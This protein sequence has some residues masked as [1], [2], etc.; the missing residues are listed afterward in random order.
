M[1]TVAIKTG[2]KEENIAI[3][4]RRML[5]VED[6]PIQAISLERLLCKEGY[7]VDWAKNG[8]EALEKARANRPNL[9]LTDTIM[10]VM[11]G[12]QLSVKLKQDK[13]LRDIPLIIIGALEETGDI[14]K[15]LECG[16]EHYITKPFDEDFLTDKVDFVIR[17]PIP[18]KNLPEEKCIEIPYDRDCFK[19]HAGRGQSLCLLLSTYENI[20]VRNKKMKQLQEELISLNESRKSKEQERKKSLT[21]GIKEHRRVIDELEQICWMLSPR[22]LSSQIGRYADSD[23]AQGYGD[24]TLLNFDG[25]ISSHVD[26]P[27][28]LGI[29]SEYMDLLETSSAIHEKNGS[30]AFN[31]HSSRWCR[32]LNIASRKLCQTKDNATALASNKWLCHES[33]WTHCSKEAIATG[34]TLDI[35]CNGGIRIYSEPIFVN[36]EAIGAINF[37]YGD[38][39]KDPVTLQKIADTYGVEYEELSRVADAYE[40][41]PPF[42]I[43][44]AK[45]RLKVSASLIGLLVE[46]EIAEVEQK[47]LQAQLIQAQKMEAIGTLTGGIA[48]DFNN[49][50]TVILGYLDLAMIQL[51]PDLPVYANLQVAQNASQRAAGIVKQLLIF[52]R[53]QPMEESIINLNNNIENLLKMLNRFVGEDIHLETECAVDL[54]NIKG[55]MTSLDQIL[56]NLVLNARDSMVQGGRIIIRTENMSLDD[57]FCKINPE[58]HPGNYIRLTVTDT[59][60]GIDPETQQHI[61][62][63]F[64]TTKKTGMGTGLGLSVTYGV[65][66]EHKGWITVFSK[67]GQ[68][69]TF[70]VYLPALHEKTIKSKE[71]EKNHPQDLLGKGERI[72]V[73]DDDKIIKDLI[74]KTLKMNN[75]IV[76]SAGNAEEAIEIFVREKGDFH[77]VLSDVVLPEKSGLDLIGDLFKRRA[78]LPVLLFSGYTDA[79]SQWSVIKKKEIPFIAKPFS[80]KDLLMA[81]KKAMGK[82]DE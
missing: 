13:E 34:K 74:T 37:G 12:Y 15:A 81:V 33:S 62:E 78:E 1:S 79:K 2:S 57:D 67:L 32:F 61:F 7:V 17:N 71:K 73:V 8:A 9:I 20:L 35:E 51:Q 19:I 70:D 36:D 41:R 42:I 53:R 26:K 65:V 45:R 39:P 75:Y 54:W 52:S 56:M 5:I 31:T 82:I 29:V 38:P 59:G 3:D 22:D 72:L 49:V 25:I 6:N 28:L 27:I 68:G 18:Y 46:R 30:Y 55:D 77:L 58:A 44:I 40:T 80:L 43:E 21:A 50:L 64:Y 14:I 11:D 76:L 48:H 69:T 23:A 4:K 47:K 66:K 63:P 10:P 24:L 16:A 60:T